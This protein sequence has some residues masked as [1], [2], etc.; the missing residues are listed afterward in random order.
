[1][2]V[3]QH[4]RFHLSAHDANGCSSSLGFEGGK[5]E[6]GG[7]LGAMTT[8]EPHCGF[9]IPGKSS[10]KASVHAP[11]DSKLRYEE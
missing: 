1:M 4:D 6:A 10:H 8:L 9:M 7:S 3:V 2:A 5:K 11:A